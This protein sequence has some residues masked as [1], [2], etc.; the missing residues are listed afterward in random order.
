MR[1]FIGDNSASKSHALK[2]AIL[3]GLF[4]IAS[5][6]TNIGVQVI[7]IA[8]YHGGYAVYVSLFIGTGVGL[9]TK[10]LMDKHFIFRF[11]SI[12][13]IHHGQTFLFYTSTGVLT[14]AIFWGFELTFHFLFIRPY[15]RYLGGIIGLTIGYWVKYQLDKKYVFHT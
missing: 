15:M 11:K 3:Y 14:T 4:A 9:I 8:V 5:I 2:I 7:S 1:E 13:L 6:A 10:F 12:N